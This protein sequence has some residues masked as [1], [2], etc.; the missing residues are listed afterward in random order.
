MNEE[1]NELQAI[2]QM[3][4][5]NLGVILMSMCLMVLIAVI[6]LQYLPKKYKSTAILNIQAGYFQNALVSDLFP[7]MS[8]PSEQNAQRQ[9]LLRLA[10]T[11]KFLDELGQKHQLF[12]HPFGSTLHILE[13]DMLLRQIEYFPQNATTFQISVLA[14][15][16]DLAYNLDRE[17]VA[18][19]VNTLIEERH[20]NLVRIKDAI[21]AHVQTLAVGLKDV[22]GPAYTLH[23]EALR[24][25]LEKING[26]I[27]A[28]TNQFTERHPDVQRL[29]ER[30]QAIRNV[31]SNSQNPVG[32]ASDAISPVSK[33]A[34]QDVYNDLVKKLNYL[35]IVV[36]MERNTRDLPYLAVIQQPTIPVQPTFPPAFKLILLGVF[37]GVVVSALLVFFLE[38][39]RGTFLAPASAAS[40]LGVPLLGQLPRLARRHG[41]QLLDGPGADAVR[42]LLPGTK[43]A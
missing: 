24:E 6:A 34:S 23:P 42:L 37:G 31:L 33:T 19:M 7:Q 21:E 35:K 29:K 39:K 30:A 1:K 5:R 36:E 16:P 22:A 4:W 28:L 18:Q 25:E 2:A 20:R 13:R 17:V 38:L 41:V 3:L 9:S 10:L 11:D 26:D 8:D 12:K 15:Q 32:S 27:K 14:P 43:E 40:E